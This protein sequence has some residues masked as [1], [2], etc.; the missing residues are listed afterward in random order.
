MSAD[1]LAVFIPIVALFI[2]IIVIVS[3]HQQRMAEIIRGQHDA[4]LR[5][6]LDAV[7]QELGYVRSILNSHASALEAVRI[8]SLETDE[9]LAARMNNQS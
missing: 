9:S 3:R 8:K 2:P 6:E 4:G 1:T 7:K 5:A